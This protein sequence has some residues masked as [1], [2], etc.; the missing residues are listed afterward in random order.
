MANWKKLTLKNNL[1]IYINLDAVASM[2]RAHLDDHTSIVFN[3]GKTD[4]G[5]VHDVAVLDRPED[6]LK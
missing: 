1:K 6:I 3:G 4:K 2:E 5:K